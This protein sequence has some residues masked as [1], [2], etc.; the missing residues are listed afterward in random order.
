[1][2]AWLA[3]SMIA[4]RHVILIIAGCIVRA[5]F[6]CTEWVFCTP[7]LQFLMPPDPCM[8]LISRYVMDPLPYERFT[9]SSPSRLAPV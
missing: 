9:P 8:L 6:G 4:V 5:P 3:T 1:M 2:I 7:S